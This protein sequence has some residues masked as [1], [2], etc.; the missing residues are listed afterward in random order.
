MQEVISYTFLNKTDILGWNQ[1]NC[2]GNFM[3]S[4]VISYGTFPVLPYCPDER[5]HVLSEKRSIPKKLLTGI[6]GEGPP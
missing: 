3:S 6:P 1:W 4:S 2:G 5:E